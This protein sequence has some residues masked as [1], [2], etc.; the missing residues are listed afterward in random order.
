[1]TRRPLELRMIRKL[2]DKPYFVF[3][4]DFG[5]KE[6]SDPKEVT[7]IIEELTDKETGN[8]KNISQNPITCSVY[9]SHV[10]DLT[11]IDLPGITRNPVKG[12]P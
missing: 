6:F 9:S 4:K 10:P 12:Q 1:M 7:K 5:N 8:S 11:L 3:P 2:V